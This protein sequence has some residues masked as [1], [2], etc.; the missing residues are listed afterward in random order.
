MVSNIYFLFSISYMGCHP[1]PIDFHSIMFQDGEIAPPT[2]LL[3]TIINH[4]INN[5]I[6]TIINSIFYHQDSTNPSDLVFVASVDLLDSTF[7]N[8]HGPKIRRRG[9]VMCKFN[10]MVQVCD[11]RNTGIY[12]H[13][14]FSEILWVHRDVHPLLMG[15]VWDTV[16]FHNYFSKRFFAL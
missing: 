7:A 12:K 11:M 4:I 14:M 13:R 8:T 1:N 6:L 3:L 9:D 16:R 5:H 15:F 2:R 10:L